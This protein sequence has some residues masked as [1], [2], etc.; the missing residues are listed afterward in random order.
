M[1]MKMQFWFC[2]SDLC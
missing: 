2:I 1:A